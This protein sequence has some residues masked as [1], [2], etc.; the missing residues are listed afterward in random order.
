VFGNDKTNQ[1]L[2]QEKRVLRRMLE[3]ERDEVMRGWRKP[4]NGE[5]HDFY[6]SPNIIRIMSSRRTR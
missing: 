5:L 6:G 3:L 1:N 4:H 2:I